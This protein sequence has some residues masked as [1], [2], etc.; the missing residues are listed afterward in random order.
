[1]ERAAYLISGGID[2]PVAAYLGIKMGWSPLFIYFDNAPFT[3]KDT[4]DRALRTIKRVAKATGIGG[5]VLVVPHGKDLEV[6][7]GKCPRNLT[8]LLCK[9]MMYRK[10]ERIAND[11]GCTAIVT[12][13]ILGEQASQT[14]RN[15]VLNS[16]IVKIPIIRPLIGMNKREVED[17]GRAIGTFEISTEKAKSCSAAAIKARTRARA[18]E[19]NDA[20]NEIPVQE[21]LDIGV[22]GSR[23]PNQA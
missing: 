15:L 8:C 20:E 13:E 1:M 2:S 6:I 16:A 9:R 4:E 10:A 17:I 18:E 22:K 23:V 14:L 21:L 11:H 19:L 5:E 12:G 7:V 3:G